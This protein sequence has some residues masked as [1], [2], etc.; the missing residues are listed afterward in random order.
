TNKLM[1]AAA[2][3]RCQS[4]P[5]ALTAQ[6]LEELPATASNTVPFHMVSAERAI[7]LNR[8]ADAEREIAFAAALEPANPL[9]QLNLAGL[10]LQS[11]NQT[12][13]SEARATLDRLRTDPGLGPVALRSLVDYHLRRGELA[14]A[15]SYS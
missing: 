8:L 9:H 6:I 13:A 5:F 10:R 12:L 15:R 3:L 2:A 7:K 1:L 11:T 4:P 14:E